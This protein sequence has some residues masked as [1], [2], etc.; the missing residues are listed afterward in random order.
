M[1]TDTTILFISFNSTSAIPVFRLILLDWMSHSLQKES[2]WSVFFD[3]VIA[4]LP[5]YNSGILT[6]RRREFALR[7]TYERNILKIGNLFEK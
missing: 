4:L 1:L 3:D 5:F 6:T 2:L 7:H